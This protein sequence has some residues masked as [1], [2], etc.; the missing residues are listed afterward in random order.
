[1]TSRTPRDSR[2]HL[3][4][5]RPIAAARE[6]VTT[7]RKRKGPPAWGASAP[8]PPAGTPAPSELARHARERL[9]GAVRIARWADAER[10]RDGGG[11]PAPGGTGALSG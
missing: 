11:R 7:R 8:T 6:A 9:S 2:L 1:M 10:T 3:V 5:R 4:P